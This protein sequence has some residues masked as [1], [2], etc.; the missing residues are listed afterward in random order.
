M[1]IGGG[2]LGVPLLSMF[3]APIRAAVATA[4][5]FGL[6]I[7]VP[8]TLGFV[9]GGWGD[10][11]LPPWSLGYVSLVGFALIVPTSI[12]ATPWGVHLAHSIPPLWLKRAFALFLALTSLR[13]FY[14]L[15]G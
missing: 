3:G 12:L 10:P 8:A 7:S 15:F 14:S 4:S 5:A 13:M 11:R 1:G 2:T 6:I 9:W